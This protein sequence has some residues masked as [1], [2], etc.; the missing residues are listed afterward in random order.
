[1]FACLFLVFSLALSLSVSF[2]VHPFFVIHDL[3]PFLK[4]RQAYGG[5]VPGKGIIGFKLVKI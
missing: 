3:L 2:L 1:M 4:A 5:G